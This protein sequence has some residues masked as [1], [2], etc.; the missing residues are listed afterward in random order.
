VV[1]QSVVAAVDHSLGNIFQRLYHLIRTA[2]EGGTHVLPTLEESIHELQSLLELFIDYAAPLAVVPRPIRATDV[3]ASL[4]QHLRVEIA[5]DVTNGAVSVDPARLARV[6]HLLGQ[7]LAETGDAAP[8]LATC[9]TRDAQLE[10]SLVNLRRTNGAAAELRWAVAEKLIELQ[11]GEL[12]P[13]AE[14][15]QAGWVLRLPLVSS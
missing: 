6:F 8:A 7:S 15:E 11:G 4:Q 13:L 14:P 5:S 3:C 1:R 12:R 9:R 2:R 10:I